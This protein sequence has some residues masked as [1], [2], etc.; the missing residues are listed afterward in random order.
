MLEKED[1]RGIPCIRRERAVTGL[2]LEDD[3]EEEEADMADA[4]RRVEG[5]PPRAELDDRIGSFS[6]A[7]MA[8]WKCPRMTQ[9]VT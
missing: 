9:P 1:G 4:L 5:V 3:D 6:K 2:E 8:A 7:A